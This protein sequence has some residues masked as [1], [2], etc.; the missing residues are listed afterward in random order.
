MARASTSGVKNSSAVSSPPARSSSVGPSARAA[1]SWSSSGVGGRPRSRGD[2]RAG[3]AA[4]GLG[5][6]WRPQS[7][8]AQSRTRRR[9]RGPGTYGQRPCAALAGP[10]VSCRGE[11]T[12][13]Q[14]CR[15]RLARS[16]CPEQCVCHAYLGAALRLGTTA[17]AASRRP[18]LRSSSW[19]R[20]MLASRWASYDSAMVPGLRGAVV[21]ASLRSNGVAA[22]TGTKPCAVLFLRRRRLSSSASPGAPLPTCQRALAGV[23]L[24]LVVVVVRRRRQV[25]SPSP[26]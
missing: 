25:R 15:P 10:W 19:L 24:A 23:V 2:A 18:R 20:R 4:F 26:I 3:A 14:A 17:V 13:A 16:Q 12:T 11:M 9:A 7:P 22:L 6:K 5:G 21:A 1:V 8:L